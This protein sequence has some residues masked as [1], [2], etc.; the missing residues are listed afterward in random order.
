MMTIPKNQ[1]AF[2]P[3]A[4]PTDR[5]PDGLGMTLRDYFAALAMH[6]FHQHAAA[7]D[8]ANDFNGGPWG[9][10]EVAA[11]AYELADAMLAEREKK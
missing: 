11:F 5:P 3:P 6:A 8:K 2:P 4:W 1:P 9:N 10:T 7:M